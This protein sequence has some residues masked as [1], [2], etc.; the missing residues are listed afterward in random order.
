MLWC[1]IFRCSWNRG[2]QELFTSATIVVDTPE[3]VAVERLMAYRGFSEAD[4]R[5]RIASQ[6][7][8]EQRLA[9]A[10]FVVRNGGSRG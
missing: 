1:S 10:D 5:S 6:A 9:A 8:R 7:S 2:P 3:D 4:A